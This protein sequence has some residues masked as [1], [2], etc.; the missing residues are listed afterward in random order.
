MALR[1]RL[2]VVCSVLLLAHASAAAQ[3]AVAPPPH[4]ALDELVKEYKRFGL[5]LPPPN[6]EL[7]RVKLTRLSGLPDG[8]GF[9][10]PPTKPGEDPKYLVGSSHDSWVTSSE[11][12][13]PG[14]DI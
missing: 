7:V 1:F 11:A 2:V 9:R 10:I 3:P 8:L 13:T 12:I 14:S 6:A 4:L 5:P